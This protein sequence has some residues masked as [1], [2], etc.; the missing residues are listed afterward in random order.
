MSLIGDL[1]SAADRR[2]R[3]RRRLRR[4]KAYIQLKTA[5][6]VNERSL[7]SGFDHLTE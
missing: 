4:C 5:R 3:P 6:P 7:C 2:A 1:G